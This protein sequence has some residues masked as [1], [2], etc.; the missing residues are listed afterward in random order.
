ME[1]EDRVVSRVRDFAQA[2]LANGFDRFPANETR[3]S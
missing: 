3:P 2:P 1:C